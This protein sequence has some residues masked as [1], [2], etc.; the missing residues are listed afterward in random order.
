MSKKLDKRVEQFNLI[1]ESLFPDGVITPVS[2]IQERIAAGTH[3]VRDGLIARF[4]AK[5]IAIDP[6][7]LKQDETKDFAQA[8][9]KSFPVNPK[10]PTKNVEGFSQILGVASRNNISLDSSFAELDQASKSTD[11]NSNLRTTIVSPIRTDVT[12]VSE[13]K[14]VKASSTVGKGKLAKGAVPSGVLKGIM[15]GIGDIP[16][17]VMR[18]AV[19]ASMLGLRGTDLSGIATTAELAEQTFPARPYYDPQS[20]TLISPDPELPGQGRKGKGP[21][22][23]LGP[24]MKQIMDRRY[25]A[26]VDGE[27]FPNIGTNK[28]AAALN[29]YVYT[30]IDKETLSV[31]KK[32]PSGYTDVRRIVA[33]AIANQLGDPQAAAEIISHTGEAGADKIDRVM[34]GFYTDVENLDSLEARRSALVGFESLMADATDS[35]NAKSLGQYLK[36]QLPEDFNADYPKI[37]IK[38]SKVGSAVQVTEATPEQIEAGRQLDLAQT[39]VKTET[40]RSDAVRIGKN[41]DLDTIARGENATAVA[42]AELKLKQAGKEV[43]QGKAAEATAQKAS[44]YKGTLASIINLYGK[45]PGPVKKAIPFAGTAYGL[46]EI[47]E[48]QAGMS[49]QMQNMGIPR[50]VANPVA[51]VGAGLNFVAGEVSPVSPVDA[52]RAVSNIPQRPSM[53]QA[54]DTR[55]AQVQDVG[56]E[57]GNLDSQGQPTPSGPVNIPNPVPSRQGMLAAGGA[58]QRVNQARSAAL[59]GEETSMS[60]S[61]LN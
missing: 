14:L 11:F 47:P 19:V 7:L 44:A 36:L 26:A 60:G 50:A 18:D 51:S 29:K 33:S 15:D 27:L 13:G 53:M 49:E 35:S 22:R 25:A 45:V 20:G 8:M 5:G 43:A 48:V 10:S 59:A 30:K 12:S 34:T 40:A 16:D 24:V 1:K 58:K 42:E 28:I 41:T 4:Y 55:Q 23:P 21:D 46:A 38:G 61:F 9:Q 3:T 57:F 37:E 6:G 32:K 39:S 54:A 31:L 56:D 52:A 2:E 17:P